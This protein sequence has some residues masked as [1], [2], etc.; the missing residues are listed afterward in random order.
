MKLRSPR[1]YIEYSKVP[2]WFW[3]FLSMQGPLDSW[4]N[5]LTSSSFPVLSRVITKS[6]P[7]SREKEGLIEEW[8]T[9]IDPIIRPYYGCISWVFRVTRSPIC[10]LPCEQRQVSMQQSD[11]FWHGFLCE[12]CW[13]GKAAPFCGFVVYTVYIY[14]YLICII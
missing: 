5:E 8:L 7:T 13:C 2:F 1:R 11:L 10:L 3:C 6:M 12:D 14:I 9:S 4:I